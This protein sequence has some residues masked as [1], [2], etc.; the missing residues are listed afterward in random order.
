MPISIYAISSYS[1]ILTILFQ[2]LFTNNKDILG[3]FIKCWSF[4]LLDVQIIT[5]I[6]NRSIHNNYIIYNLY[7]FAE[8]ILIFEFVRHLKLIKLD[9]RIF[10]LIISILLFLE[11]IYFR[12]FLSP[13]SVLPYI[14]PVII[15]IL[16]VYSTFKISIQK[17]NSTILIFNLLLISN[18]FSWF[19]LDL[20]TSEIINKKISFPIIDIWS[21][22]QN[23][24]T[25]FVW[26]FIIFMHRNNRLVNATNK[27]FTQH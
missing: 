8:L 17:N 3:D 9:K 24:L 27:N 20:F 22:L 18:T 15:L 23:F 21:I 11:F 26:L 5:D 10:L 13:L 1:I 25:S 14:K 16:L 12:N 19:L 4:I 2:G 7:E 6:L